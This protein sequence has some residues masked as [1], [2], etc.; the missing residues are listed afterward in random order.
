MILILLSFVQNFQHYIVSVFHRMIVINCHKFPE[1]MKVFSINHAKFCKM[2]NETYQCN[3]LANNITNI[4][5]KCYLELS[6][7]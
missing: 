4:G 7:S 2:I 6:K 5:Y 1:K 3:L